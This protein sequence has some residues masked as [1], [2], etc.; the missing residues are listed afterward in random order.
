M[1]IIVN[2]KAIMSFILLSISSSFNLSFDIFL[3]ELAISFVRLF[4]S[5]FVIVAFNLDHC[6][7]SKLV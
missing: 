3:N 7:S 4:V 1:L 6:P 2:P 5:T